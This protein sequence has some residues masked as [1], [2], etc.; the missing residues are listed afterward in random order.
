[1][2]IKLSNR[3]YSA[4]QNSSHSAGQRGFS[5]LEFVVILIAGGILIGA[6]ISIYQKFLRL[7][8]DQK[9]T[10]AIERELTFT[11][12]KL[13]QLLTTLPG[14]EIGFYSG[15][16]YG[17]PT[18]LPANGKITNGNLTQNLQLGFVTPFK[19]DGNDAI[20]IISGSHDSSRLEL[21]DTVS[22]KGSYGIAHV[23]VPDDSGAH[24]HPSDKDSSSSTSFSET[25]L[26]KNGTLMLLVGSAPYSSIRQRVVI[27]TAR[28][29]RIINTPQFTTGTLSSQSVVEIRFDFCDSGA[30]SSEYPYL[31][32]SSS[33]RIF[34]LG[35]VLVPV[36]VSSIYL[37]KLGD[38]SVIMHNKGG[39]I[40]P[41][42]SGKDFQIIGGQ[43]TLIGESDSLK[44]HYQLA[45]GQLMDSPNSP[46]NISWL[47]EITGVQIELS[48]E[49]RSATN[50]QPVTRTI[51]RSFELKA[52]NL[53]KQT[54]STST[55]TGT[56]SSD[57]GSTTPSHTTR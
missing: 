37:T 31:S 19:V 24:T 2:S 13:G 39:A 36:S 41:S 45:D 43:D 49:T 7:H 14:R 25:V 56:G 21:T 11:Q 3:S 57:S 10:A 48:K 1:M 18:A 51:T 29:V 40:L 23:A 22:D 50:A 52:R 42:T 46:L 54:A 26:P 5:L 30:C 33:N 9:Q 32:N 35:S 6:T 44:V 55:S 28:L 47:K 8:R 17:V 12:L 20:T 53:E 16:D 15:A 27:P 38:A 34:G 4:S